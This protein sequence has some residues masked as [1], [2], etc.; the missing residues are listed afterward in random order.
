MLIFLVGL[1]GCGKST[2]GRLLAEEL[3]LP[4]FDT[5]EIIASIE[6]MS[7]SEIFDTQGELFFRTLEK[8][9]IEN[10][11]M[12][13]AV[14]ATGGGLPCYHQLMEKL[15]ALGTTIWLNTAI[16]TISDR[17]EGDDSR[18]LLKNM[19]HSGRLRYLS[20][21]FKERKIFYASAKLTLRTTDDLPAM[22]QKIRRKL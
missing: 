6:D 17:L 11:K 16:S 4:Y 15:N 7:V 22:I 9:I 18:P 12:T 3:M 1:T 10:W 2:I 13:N 5:D 21:L 8:N 19:T 14:V 20:A